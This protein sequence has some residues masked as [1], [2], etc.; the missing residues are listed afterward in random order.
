MEIVL[1][2][3]KLSPCLQPGLIRSEENVILTNI[4]NIIVGTSVT[5]DMADGV[6]TETMT[7]VGALCAA[8]DVTHNPQDKIMLNM[9]PSYL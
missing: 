9:P 2:A 7:N 5:Y 4:L 1:T 6:H 8:T 3:D